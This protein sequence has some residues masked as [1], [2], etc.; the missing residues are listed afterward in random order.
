MNVSLHDHTH[1]K[2]VIA[3]KITTFTRTQQDFRQYLRQTTQ[4]ADMF[5]IHDSRSRLKTEW[6]KSSQ[7]MNGTN[8]I[9]RSVTHTITRDDKLNC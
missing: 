3:P 8:D 1:Y 5:P 2:T 7:L 6:F 4:T 9:L